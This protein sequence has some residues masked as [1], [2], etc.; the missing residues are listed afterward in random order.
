M[1]RAFVS[2]SAFVVLDEPTA[3]LDPIVECKMYENFA[4]IFSHHGAIMIS[5]R[6]ASAKMADRILVL[7]KGKIVEE[8]THQRLMEKKGVYEKMYTV[9]TAWYKE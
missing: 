6:L 2:N 7:D 3:A 1:A 5:H 4:Q 8:G 9:Q